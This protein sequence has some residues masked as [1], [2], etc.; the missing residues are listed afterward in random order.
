MVCK[1]FVIPAHHKAPAFVSRSL[2]R[3]AG[4]VSALFFVFLQSAFGP[5]MI[6]I[7]Q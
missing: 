7:S 3:M 4:R 5:G 6:K 1:M 2:A